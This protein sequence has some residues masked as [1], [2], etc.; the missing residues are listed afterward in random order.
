MNVVFENVLVLLLGIF[1]GKWEMF[2]QG[3]RGDGVDTHLFAGG[4]WDQS[5]V[6]HEQ[7]HVA[8][9]GYRSVV[10]SCGGFGHWCGGCNGWVLPVVGC[11]FFDAGFLDA[12]S[13]R[14][15]LMLGSGCCGF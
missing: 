15:F 14:W 10:Q 4:V 8:R 2:K 12:G 7:R 5:V 6:V 9:G 3:S 13:K 1:F 11:W